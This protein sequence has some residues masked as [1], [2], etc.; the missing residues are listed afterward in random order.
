MI[1]HPNGK[2]LTVKVAEEYGFMFV[3]FFEDASMYNCCKLEWTLQK[4]YDH[5]PKNGQRRLWFQSGSGYDYE[6]KVGQCMV[7]ISLSFEIKAAMEGGKLI[8]GNHA[9]TTAY[10]KKMQIGIYYKKRN[11]D[12]DDTSTTDDDTS[13]T[14]V[15]TSTIDDGTSTTTNNTNDDDDDRKPA[16]V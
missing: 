6:N 10:D 16:A 4:M 14:D 9:L 12:D 1:T 15:D 13:T 11:D 5:L 8:K 3:P 2:R 7:Y